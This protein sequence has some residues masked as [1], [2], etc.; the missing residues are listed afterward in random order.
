[1]IRLLKNIIFITALNLIILSNG[2][3]IT[4]LS[5]EELK[6]QTAQ[7]GMSVAIDNAVV[8]HESS[9]LKFID[10]DE[11]DAGYLGF[12]DIKQLY[13]YNTGDVDVDGDGVMGH[14]NIDIANP[15]ESVDHYSKPFVAMECSDW[16]T[17]SFFQAGTIDFNGTEIGSLAITGTGFPEWNLYFGAH[18]A[19]IDFEAGFKAKINSFK[20]K[21]GDPANDHWLGFDNLYISNSFSGHSDDPSDPTTWVS[22]GRFKIG[23]FQNNKP[24]TFDIGVRESDNSPAIFLSTPMTGSVR[25]ENIHIESNDFGP[26]AIDGIKVHNMS[27][28]LPGRN[29]G[30]GN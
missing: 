16:E 26:A 27:I 3:A 1:M 30:M 9:S 22:E 4:E 25:M 13:T 17:L 28:E 21:Y 15:E 5:R 18:D 23:D 20:Y 7:A 6:N 24:A 2:N 14:L 29:L 11:T 10:A 12:R 19:G 8:Y